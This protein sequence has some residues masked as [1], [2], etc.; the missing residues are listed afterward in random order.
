MQEE[1]IP[2]VGI[3]KA[4]AST[5]LVLD[6]ILIISEEVIEITVVT[7]QHV[8]L[9]NRSMKSIENTDFRRLSLIGRENG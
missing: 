3:L 8:S 2:H 5:F 6:A 4:L 9:T 7:A 1:C